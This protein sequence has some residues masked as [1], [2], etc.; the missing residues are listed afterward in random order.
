MNS[1][2]RLQ[3]LILL[4]DEPVAGLQDDHLGIEPFA[5][6]IA[7]AAVGTNGPFTIGVFANWGEGKTSLL[8]QAKALVDEHRPEI[9]TVWFNAWQYEK[10]DHPIV[11]LVAS[12]VRAVDQKLASPKKLS[13]KLTTALSSV[14]RALRAVAYGF[15]AKTKVA[16]PG[17]A[18]V[19]AGFVAKE[20]ID[21]YDKL[22][23]AGDPLLDRTLYYNAF[24]T[25]ESVAGRETTSD[26]AIKIVVFIDDLDRCL[27]PQAL[28]LLE[29]I[30]LVLAQRGFIFA[31]AVDRRVLES[32]LAV[33]YRKEY[34]MPDY[35][36]SGTQYLDKIVQLPLALPSHRARFRGY[37]ERLLDGPVFQN[38]SNE[39]VRKTVSQFVDV[40]AAGS[41]HNPRN[42][43]RFL[44]NL[45]IDRQIW[46]SVLEQ[47]GVADPESQLDAVRLGL[48]AV[49]RILRQHLGDSLYRW[50]T[51][52]S[53]VCETLVPDEWKTE[54]SREEPASATFH[55]RSMTEL[56]RRL[57]ESPFLHDLLHTDTGQLWLTDHEAR[58]VVDEFL[59]QQREESPEEQD[60]RR[61][62][63][64][65]M[66][67][68]HSRRRLGAVRA[69]AEKWPDETTRTLLGECAR[70]DKSKVVRLTA[71][72]TLTEKWPDETTRR[73]L[74]ERAVQDENEDVRSY[75]LRI[76]AEKWPH[77][78]TRKLHEERVV[79]DEDEGI[80]LAALQVLAEKWPD[81]TTRRLLEELA[82]QDENEDVRRYALL[83]SAEKWP[84]EATR[85]DILEECAVQNENVYA[86]S[87]AIQ[88]L[89]QKWRDDTTRKLLEERAIH[90]ES[91]DVRRHAIEALATK[92][93]DHTMRKLLEER[94]VRDENED[95]RS[96][97]LQ[98]LADKYSDH[99]TRELL[100]ERAVKDESQYARGAALQALAK[101]WPGATTRKPLEERR[102]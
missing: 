100:E 47:Q 39:M 37:I 1:Q 8:K 13:R 74:E 5:R 59:V 64:E 77:E 43:V 62:L 30:K 88:V 49:S 3:P 75:A 20:M 32:F 54:P 51:G 98:A 6:V 76:L 17:F 56:L 57:D 24:E 26:G 48:C 84:D 69:L 16:V 65:Q 83:I 41:N 18:E 50:L 19:E 21:R 42:L 52:N 87:N 66:L 36:T 89:A 94:A 102:R 71:L 86:R 60:D 73:L 23:S 29:S 68:N 7:G 96:A 95:V 91:E 14:S 85:R 53:E 78:T 9:V 11:P 80:R 72:K 58:R 44:N 46:L 97:A 4:E 63:E 70:E 55:D 15:S 33:R 34:G 35:L 67:H 27:P 79:Q 82:V 10:E 12:I 92:W 22:S 28:K 38:P 90:D 81:E 45:I 101:K 93:W 40:L 31:L 2:A 99:T 61:S 25:L